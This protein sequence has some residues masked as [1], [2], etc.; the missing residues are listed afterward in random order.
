MARDPVAGANA[1]YKFIDLVSF[2]STL[3]TGLFAEIG[4]GL[5]N[6]F[7]TEANMMHQRWRQASINVETLSER[8]H[9]IVVQMQSLA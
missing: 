6:I 5:S 1:R 8:W 9:T 2:Q 3:G 7:G 4:S